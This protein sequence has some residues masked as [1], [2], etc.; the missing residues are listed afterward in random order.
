MTTTYLRNDGHVQ[1]RYDPETAEEFRREGA[2]APTV[3]FLCTSCRVGTWGM[4]LLKLAR[5]LCDRCDWLDREVGYLAGTP[6]RRTGKL[7]KGAK[8]DLDLPEWKPVVAAR[9]YNVERLSEVFTEAERLGVPTT[10]VTEMGVS[11]LAIDVDDV[12]RFNLIPSEPEDYVRRLAEWFRVLGPEEYRDRAHVFDDVNGLAGMFRA[13][14]EVLQRTR[15]QRR[16]GQ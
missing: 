3:G 14:E 2:S 9:Q 16:A 11:H 13:R 8:I 6:I 10:E 1:V 4:F 7:T 5:T 15:L 12:K